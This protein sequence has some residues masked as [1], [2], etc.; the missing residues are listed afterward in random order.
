MY[1]PNIV[2]DSNLRKIKRKEMKSIRIPMN[3]YDD[4]IEEN[5]PYKVGDALFTKEQ[6]VR[7]EG[8]AGKHMTLYRADGF[9]DGTNFISHGNYFKFLSFTEARDMPDAAARTFVRITNCAHYVLEQYELTKVRGQEFIENYA[10]YTL[11]GNIYGRCYEWRRY[12]RVWVYDFELCDR[13]PRF[14]N[15]ISK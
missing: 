6:G 13:P 4:P 2:T 12:P 15:H 8:D 14:Y 11:D 5:A 1:Y 3:T 10:L 9:Y 7:V